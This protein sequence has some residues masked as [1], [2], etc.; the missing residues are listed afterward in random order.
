MNPKPIA[1]AITNPEDIEISPENLSNGNPINT[2]EKNTAKS[3]VELK[4][5]SS[6]NTRLPLDL[7]SVK[8]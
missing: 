8:L 4:K 3:K 6:R 2:V 1:K 5:S 7:I